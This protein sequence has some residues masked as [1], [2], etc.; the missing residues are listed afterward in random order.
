MNFGTPA[1]LFLMVG[2]LPVAAALVW[3]ARW[4]REAVR[5]LIGGGTR[6]SGGR[7]ALKAALLLSALAFV[8]LAAARPQRGSKKVLLPREGNDVMIALDVSLSMLATDVSPNRFDHTKAILGGLL[9]RLQGD[10]VG[11]VVFAGTAA[12]RMPLTTDMGVARE[13]IQSAAIKE[14]GLAAG[15]G[16]GDAIRVGVTSFPTDDHTRGKVLLI[17]SD[18]EDLAGS[19]QDAVRSARD[20]GIL[21]YTM[22]V[23]TDAG[24]AIVIPRTRGT[25]DRRT[26]EP[27]ATAATSRRDD[28]TLR[29][30]AGAG[31]G[32]YVDGNGDDPAA[33]IAEEIGR[34]ART[35]FE[36]QEGTLP[37]ERFQPFAA[38][39]LVLLALE[40]LIP[41][42]RRRG[43]RAG[44]PGRGLLG[45]R[46]DQAA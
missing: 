14:G 5:R 43:Q 13:L 16:I 11:L 45:R 40:F 29:Q 24:G 44:A 41:D 9:D 4:R 30:L 17:V 3:L 18:G 12:L 19:P 36:S 8:V 27:A 22:G 32:R 1:L 25:T 7:R 31:R 2:L 26:P 15:T 37:I 34:L 20:R 21:V 42:Q 10:R 6:A 39:A 33:D 46:R 23:G 38:I 28:G 35:K